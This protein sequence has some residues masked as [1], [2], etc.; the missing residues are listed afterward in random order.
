VYITVVCPQ[1]LTRYQIDPAYRGVR[2]RCPNSSC[3]AVFEARE[4]SEAAP[5]ARPAA[6]ANGGKTAPGTPRPKSAPAPQ[7]TGSVGD[8]VP[9]LP[10]AADAPA[11][12]APAAQAPS[13]SQAP[14]PRRGGGSAPGAAPPAAAAPEG[15][16]DWRQGPPP[17]RPGG[18]AAVPPPQAR[19]AGLPPDGDGD[20]VIEV[21]PDEAGV[22]NWQ[23]APP[24]RRG[25]Q[26]YD[27][28]EEVTAGEEAE[29]VEEV[30]E[31]HPEKARRSKARLYILV[32][33]G[34]FVLA[35]GLGG[36][37]YLYTRIAIQRA[38]QKLHDEALAA[39]N[40]GR[41]D[42][43]V[44]K[45]TQHKEKFP[46]G[47]G[48]TE[49]EFL[50]ALSDLRGALRSP[51][52]PPDATQVKLRQFLTTFESSPF[53]KDRAPDLGQDVAPW[54]AARGDALAN[55]PPTPEAE[56]RLKD[57]RET[58]ALT[59]KVVAGAFRPEDV[60]KVQES[61]N[62][63]QVVFEKLKERT[64]VLNQVKALRPT[65]EGIKKA[66]ALIHL[67]TKKQPGF[68]QEA[69]VTAT[70][71]KLYQDHFASIKYV[72]GGV[73]DRSPA[74]GEDFEPSLVVNP[75]LRGVPPQRHPNDPVVLA[76][77]RGVLYALA[78]SNG[79][80]VWA[81]R[82]G[83]DTTSLP[84]LVPASGG[85][86][87]MVLALSADTET[88]T[89]L[90]AATGDQL[91][92]Y[93]LSAPCLGQ[94]VIV[95]L[96]A[97]I[98]TF[99]GWVNE[100]E[101]ARGQLLGHYELGQPL[102]L[103]GVRQPG[104]S[105]V[106]IPAD[107]DCVY[108]LDVA[109]HRCQGVLYTGHPSGSLR[110]APLIV[111]PEGSADVTGYLVLPQTDGLDRTR[112][113][114]YALPITGAQSV[115]PAKETP[116]TQGWPW[117]LPYQDPEKLVLVTDAG[118]VGMFGIRQ[119]RNQG[120]DPLF[121]MVTEPFRI[122]GDG[123]D[124]RTHPSRAQV[125]ACHDDALWVL[126]HGGLQKLNLVLSPTKGP[127]LAVDPQWKKALR[128]GSPLHQ[129][130]VEGTGSSTILFLV[131]QAPDRRG[132]MATAVDATT[133]QVIWQRELGL[134]AQGSAVPLGPELVALDESGAVL[135]FSPKRLA[136]QA[137]LPWQPGGQG[138]AK[139]LP[140]NP[141]FPPQLVPAGDGVTAYEVACPGQG[142]QLV[143]R[144][145]RLEDGQ[146]PP[147]KD[148]DERRLDLTAP[149]AGAAAV[150]G[151][152]LL[153]PLEDGTLLRVKLPECASGTPGPKWRSNRA[154]PGARCHV[155]WINNDDFLTT[156]GARGVTHW[157]WPEGKMYAALPPDKPEEDPTAELRRNIV[158]PPLVLPTGSGGDLMALVADSGGTLTL[159][160]GERLD[161][162]QRWELGGKITAGPFLRGGRVGCVVDGQRLALLDLGQK[163]PVWQY[164]S[165]S[166][167]PIVGEPQQ[168][169]DLLVVA[170]QSGR[171]VG[172]DP[173]T[174]R[175][176][177]P[178]FRLR[179]S[180]APVVGPLSFGPGRALAPLTDG[181]V[182]LLSLDHLRDPLERFPVVW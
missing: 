98:P 175:A 78:Q 135:A 164:E 36:G 44:S 27:D 166:E 82:V 26:P 134:V 14:P 167:G 115:P 81:M 40:E 10:A 93:R 89:A 72:E 95:G 20:E 100:V 150:R 38:E 52:A 152:T 169:E 42:E 108:V 119:Q 125:V 66:L 75:L 79:E 132:C 101:L 13:W 178:G 18:T 144:R 9:V 179:A 110:T 21:Q 8:V 163:D 92:R 87:E 118:A 29:E 31:A 137:D 39:Y 11:G 111:N 35:G 114:A 162:A 55:S 73:K 136:K 130:Q 103:G 77:V 109:A 146:F 15:G 59:Q 6:P 117:F 141:S 76:L 122:A 139:P 3:R 104:T 50:I 68:A 64:A 177:G 70:L 84:V 157:R 168:V 54:L 99:D 105:L 160:R 23:S 161:E 176:A 71:N 47:T 69:E 2:M 62:K 30:Y 48:N 45:F 142:M 58:F 143:V 16:A 159:L 145:F 85:R 19:G 129:S 24:P 131:T 123:G 155:V 49:D 127:M 5:P 128:L 106:Y 97:Y 182:L 174:G 37:M 17:R 153:L 102:S 147:P 25:G 96:K 7:L 22:P 148:E 151:T 1:C 158:A 83:I 113:L 43:A 170:H 63:V 173:A 121:P 91:W 120:D 61:F 34:L 28:L 32:L 140:D 74:R 133:G 67:E 181:T 57:L 171:Y 60:A 156:D 41:F 56:A 149:P 88:L 80:V 53:L 116:P 126:A 172:L 46:D 4:E 33:V 94:P 154:A 107:D 165:K 112:F 86:P 12:A 90:N 138:L 124:D 65:P 180:A 51:T